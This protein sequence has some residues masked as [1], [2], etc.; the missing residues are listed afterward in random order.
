MRRSPI[1][2][3]F[4]SV[5][6]IIIAIDGYSS[7]G[8][9][10]L[11]K[12]LAARFGFAY[13]DSGAMYR[14]VTLYFIE[15]H[16]G[17][18][19]SQAIEKALEAIHIHFEYNPEHR[20]NET[21]L[22]ERMVEDEIRSKPVSDLVS[23]VATIKAVR[24]AMVALQRKAAINKS[25]VMDGRD[26][27]THVFPE[28]ELKIFMTADPLV[29]AKRRFAELQA[30]GENWSMEEVIKN[31]KER[32]QIDSNREENPLRQATDSR[33]LDNSHLSEQEQLDKVIIWV[34]NILNARI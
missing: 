18:T 26:I 29:R 7:C 31:L 28:A 21:Y 10:T 19:D 23:P 8:K 9:S 30:K 1:N 16:I 24:T 11:A 12:A 15:Q 25:I 4:C 5:K 34:K 14:A 3:Y 22:N 6:P 27:G 20:R 13:V 2:G 17:L 33:V 32:D